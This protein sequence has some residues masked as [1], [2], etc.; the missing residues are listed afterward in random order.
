M[1]NQDERDRGQGADILIVDDIAENLEVLAKILT[2]EGYKVRPTSSGEFALSAIKN[3]LPD[4]ILLDIKMPGMDGYTVCKK[5]KASERTEEIPV[6]FIS[7]LSDVND[8]IHGFKVGAVDYIS[9]P[10]QYEEVLARVKTHVM[11]NKMKKSLEQKNRNLEQENSLRRI[12]EESL[13]T[14]YDE[15]E[16]KVDERTRELK[17]EVTERKKAEKEL[18]Q[19]LKELEEIKNQLL[20]ENIYLQE[21]IKLSNDFCEII[22]KSH[23]LKNVLSQLEQVSPLDST[24]LL[25]GETGTGKELFARAVHNLSPRKLHPLIKVN[26]AALPANLIE[27]ELFGHE[28]EAFSGAHSKKV[29][30]FEL[31]NHGTI[32]L[33]EVGDIPMELQAKLL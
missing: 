3:S 30:R 22:G 32:F 19:A 18:Q 8:I 6:I 24:V 31:A 1:I 10:F 20:E 28:K 4:L 12:A 11:L 25:L 21:E 16:K 9:K 5:L 29:G 23:S 2:H 26:C 7:A 27:N 14:A 15:I 17:I 33:D 13:K